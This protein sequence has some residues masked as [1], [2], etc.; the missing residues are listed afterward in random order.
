MGRG[1]TDGP[2][3]L[4]GCRWEKESTLTGCIGIATDTVLRRCLVAALASAG[5]IA[6]APVQGPANAADDP[7]CERTILPGEDVRGAFDAAIAAGCSV[8]FAAGRHVVTAR[9]GARLQGTAE[10]PIRIRGDGADN[11]F[12][13]RPST[14]HNILDI[15]GQHFEVRDLDLAGGSRGIRLEFD[16]SQATFTGLKVH[17]TADG[18]FSANQPGRTFTAITISHSEFYDTSGYGEGLYLGCNN[19]GCEFSDSTIEFNYIHDTVSTQGAE[20]GDGIDLKG[21]AF[22]NIIR[23]NV[24][25]NTWGLAVLA[26]GNGGRAQNIIDANVMLDCGGGLQ[27]TADAVVSNNVII[28]ERGRYSESG[29]IASPSNQGVPDNLQFLHNTV[30]RTGKRS[31]GRCFSARNWRPSARRMVVANN[32][33]FCPGG[34][35][36][37]MAGD[38]YR[39]AVVTANAIDGATNVPAGTFATGPWQRQLQHPPSGNAFPRAGSALIGA[40][41]PDH[42]TETDFNCLRRADGPGDVGAYRYG[43]GV[44]RGWAGEPAIKRC[45]ASPT[46]ERSATWNRWN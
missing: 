45:V 12:L 44:N 6:L 18:T 30:V 15:G 42:L 16:T 25:R 22:G 26:Y 5:L 4:S 10:A 46:D 7:R 19:D 28:Y 40:A 41:D 8:H 32:A 17:G 34:D 20:Q 23:H 43:D 2:S 24:F 31:G 3:E 38:S 39:N 14:D 29:L 21:G 13:V 27:V 9:L 36:L 11:T 33:I 1:F 35:A 37:Y